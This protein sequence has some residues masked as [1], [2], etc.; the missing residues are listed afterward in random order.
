MT[1]LERAVTQF[2]AILKSSNAGRQAEARYIATQG[3]YDARRAVLQEKS[4][5]PIQRPLVERVTL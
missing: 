5:Q 3:L 1:P 2:E 4:E